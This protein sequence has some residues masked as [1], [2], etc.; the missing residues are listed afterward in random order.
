MNKIVIKVADLYIEIRY[1]YEHTFKMCKDYIVEDTNKTDI[2]ASCNDE[3]ILRYSS[4]KDISEFIAI[5]ESIA[6]QLYKHNRVLIHG[7]SIEYNNFAYLFL[8]PSGVGKSTHIKLLMDNYKDIV[9]INGDKPIVDEEGYVYGTPWS[10]KENLNNNIKAKLKGIILVYRDSYD[11]I[12]EVSTSDYLSFILNQVYK[13][14]NFDKSI[15]IIDKAFKDI[16]VYKLSCTKN[17]SSAKITFGK[18]L[19]NNEIK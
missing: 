2:V 9:V 8:A 17:S 10:G 13:D 18:V 4:K 19:N 12:E 16:K 11:H 15:N 3:D 1:R 7:A 6:K 5:Y 14:E